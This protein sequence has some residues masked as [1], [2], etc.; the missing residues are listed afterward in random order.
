MIE[1]IGKCVEVMALD[2]MYRGKLVE[3]DETEVHLETEF[4]WVIIPVSHI[5]FIRGAEEQ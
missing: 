5:A 4:G 1:L 3:V 2:V